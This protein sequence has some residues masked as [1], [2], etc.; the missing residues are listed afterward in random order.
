MELGFHYQYMFNSL[1]LNQGF[2]SFSEIAQLAGI[3][4]TDW[5][6]SVLLADY[7]NDGAKDLYITN[8]LMRDVRNR[9]YQAMF[10]QPFDS[11][12]SK[13]ELVK[14]APSEKS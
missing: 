11:I 8:G 2:G 7:D 1:Q 14:K 4:K 9:D 13:L 5:S 12:K 10:E 3:S 6:W